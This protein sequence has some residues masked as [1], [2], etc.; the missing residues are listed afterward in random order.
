MSALT[1]RGVPAQGRNYSVV[2][3]EFDDVESFRRRK[4][5]LFKCVRARVQLKSRCRVTGFVFPLFVA[6]R[7]DG[8]EARGAEGWD[9]PADQSYGAEN[10]GGG[11]QGSGLNDQADVPGLTVLGEGAI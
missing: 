10:D 5:I 2:W 6:Q 8:I 9:H 4:S 3:W 7:F 1:R 11:D